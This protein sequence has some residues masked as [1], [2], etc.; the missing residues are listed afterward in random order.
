MSEPSETPWPVSWDAVKDAQ[1]K[2]WLRATPA[3]RLAQME[4]ILGLARLARESIPPRSP[5]AG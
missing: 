4:E 5:K 2:T 1:L 3:Q